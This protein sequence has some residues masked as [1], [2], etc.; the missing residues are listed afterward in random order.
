M[1][2]VSVNNFRANIKK[3]IDKAVT[4]H[5]P[6]RVT[7][8]AKGNFVVMSEEDWSAE[9]ETLYVLQNKSLM[10]QIAQ[11]LQTDASSKTLTTEEIHE[12]FG[13]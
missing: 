9:Q 3:I 10:R 11:A 4:D 1:E 7:R 2:A 12:E 13:V 6:V 8:K 5:V